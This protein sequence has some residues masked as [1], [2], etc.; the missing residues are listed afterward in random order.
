MCNKPME[1]FVCADSTPPLVRPCRCD[2]VA[3]PACIQRIMDEVPAHA[4][5]CAVCKTPYP[6]KQRVRCALANGQILLAY[7][8]I[9]SMLA[10]SWVLMSDEVT[11]RHFH[12]LWLISPLLFFWG[13]YNL[14]LL[15]IARLHVHGSVC[16]IDCV[17]IEVLDANACDTGV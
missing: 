12:A 3:H 1:C 17:S 9:L 8:A 11:F 4:E 14:A 15:T 16:C 2:S 5:G 10:A 13:V 6:T 7:F